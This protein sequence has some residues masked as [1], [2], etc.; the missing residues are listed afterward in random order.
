MYEF[1]LFS[2]RS[3]DFGCFFYDVFSTIFLKRF[4]FYLLEY[5][6]N[7]SVF[8]VFFLSFSLFS[9][10]LV[11]T[12]SLYI[13]EIMND[14]FFLLLFYFS[15]YVS[16][17]YACKNRLTLAQRTVFLCVYVFLRLFYP[18]RDAQEPRDRKRP[19]HMKQQPLFD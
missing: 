17:M 5:F 13:F 9:C 7:V 15:V 3:F 11:S 19:N 8:I 4:F 6:V 16:T 10:S 2:L 12:V 14:S 1:L 18:I